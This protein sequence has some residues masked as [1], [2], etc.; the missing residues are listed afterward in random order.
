M[1]TTPRLSG[2]MP[3]GRV[4]A[5]RRHPWVRYSDD[6]LLDTRLRDL[7]L[8]IEGTPLQRR[9]DKLYADLDRRG[10]RFKPHV[11]LSSEW[12][13][14]DGVPGIAI[15]FY[16]VHPRLTQLEARQMLEVE[17]GT[18]TACMR[19]LRHEAGHA[20]DTAYRLH[21]K[22]RWREIFGRYSQPY[23]EYYSPQPNSRDY[24]LHLDSWYAQAHPAEDFA[25]TFAV[26]LTPRSNWRQTYQDWPAAQRKLEYV[27]EVMTEINGR[28]PR[29]NSRVRTEP[30]SQLP[31]TLR[32]HYTAKRERY[33]AAWPDFYDDD[34]R[35]L[36]SADHRYS[37]RPTAVGFLRGIRV[38]IRHEVAQWTGAHAYTVDQVLQ[39]M[40]ER[41][42]ELRLRLAMPRARAKSQAVIMLTVHTMNC[43]YGRRHEI[44]V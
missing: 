43:L 5:R 37:D 8:R 15:P 10:I 7:R 41:C 39:D 22:K 23:P 6:A 34:L 29:I 36:F 44:P 30:L 2:R 24:V 40:I 25:E 13:S 17:G 12:F 20:I 26:W 27:D 33:G 31:Q 1:N 9:V 14:P 35:R 42:R 21:F 18:E 19:I 4:S 3:V 32:E 16:L 28:P 38:Q 11:W